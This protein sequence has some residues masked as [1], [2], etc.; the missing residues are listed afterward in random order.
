MVSAG[1]SPEGDTGYISVS[2]RRDLHE[3]INEEATKRKIPVRHYESDLLE[4]GLG[5]QEFMERYAP[6]LKKLPSNPGDTHIK[7][8]DDSGKKTEIADVY[9][10]KNE[11]GKKD[12]YCSHDESFDCIHVKFA[13]M[14]PEIGRLKW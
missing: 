4:M 10:E 1:D 14:L 12:V 9:I 8:M 13:L 11:R 5:K 7:I 6:F 2:I 3:R